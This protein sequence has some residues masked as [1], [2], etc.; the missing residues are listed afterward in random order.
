MPRFV[1]MG[2]LLIDFISTERGFSVGEAPAFAPVA[3]GAPANVAVGI[4]KLG[5][6]AGFI[7]KVGD[8]P[9]GRKLESLLDQYGVDTSALSFSEDAR[10]MLAFVSLTAEG[11]RDFVFFRH[12]SADMLITKADVPADCLKDTYAFHFG[13]ISLISGPSRETTLHLINEAKR[14][15]AIVSFD[16]NVRM[17][18][19][20][21]EAIARHE[22]RGAIPLSDIVKLSNEEAHF[23]T[24]KD[25][26]K[27][28]AREILTM[29]PKL[30]VV[31]KG[32][33]GS[34]GVTA[35]YGVEVLGFDVSTSGKKG[36]TTGAGDAFT[37]AML[38]KMFDLNVADL[39]SLTD[40]EMINI[41][42]FANAAGA[43]T[44]TGR[45]AIPALPAVD[46]I[47]SLLT[48]DRGGK[49]EGFDT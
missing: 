25:D 45:G 10:T 9:F 13:S 11:E 18:L 4:S 17:S 36:D 22:I 3:G 1:T 8:D 37:A 43:I 48:L 5:G 2:E 26:P 46:E 15:G 32:K 14:L 34:V 23:I 47:E 44:T 39:Y 33:E 30:V 20:P 31:T 16:P 24:G 12:P 40:L 7:G 29:G 21:D 19:W 42:R 49:G 28:A 41:F 6:D 27:S 35:R 38:W